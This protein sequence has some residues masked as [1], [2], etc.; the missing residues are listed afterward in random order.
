MKPI[1]PPKIKSVASSIWLTE[2]MHRWV[3]E[4]AKQ[5]GV[6]VSEV[7]RVAIADFQKRVTAK[8]K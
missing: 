1:Y 4:H 2:A 6:S 7:F 3:I 8:A 5:N